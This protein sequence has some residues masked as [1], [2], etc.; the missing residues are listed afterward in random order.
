MKDINKCC[1]ISFVLVLALILS[2]L[3]PMLSVYADTQTVKV[4]WYTEPGIQYIDDSGKRCGF[5]YDYYAQIARYE[6]VQF[7]YVS[8]S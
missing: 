1:S 4:G 5:S 7:S 3:S 2:C 6:D 8:G